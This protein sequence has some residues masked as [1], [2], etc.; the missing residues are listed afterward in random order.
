LAFL[1]IGAV[2]SL[3]ERS[4]L[5]T[6]GVYGLVRHPIYAG[7]ILT[8]LGVIL[9]FEAMIPLLYFPISVGLYFIMTVYEEKSLMAEYGREYNEYQKK[10]RKR[11]IPYFL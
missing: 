8:F 6:T 5:I 2:P 9:F 1:K 3:R 7:T 10:V 4:A 11:I